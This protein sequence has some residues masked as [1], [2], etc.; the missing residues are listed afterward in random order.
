MENDDYRAI[1]IDELES[2]RQRNPRYS[3]RAFARDLGL[4]ADQLSAILKRR[5][6]LSGARAER[7]AGKLGLGEAETL[8]FRTMV[9]ASHARSPTQRAAARRTLA[10]STKSVGVLELDAFKVVAEWHHFAILE[11]ADLDGGLLDEKTIAPRLKIGKRAA[12]AAVLRLVRLGLLARDTCA[13][14]AT[15]GQTFAPIGVSDRSKRRFLGQ[16]G[17]KALQALEEQASEDRDFASDMLSIGAGDIEE[18][19]A[20]VRTFRRGLAALADKPGKKDRVLCVN[21]QA[22]EIAR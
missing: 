21:V 12:S 11:L 1:L 4:P 19:R 15:S 2:R 17:Q 18:L 14:R 22:F 10:A 20:L 16:L 9:E 8:V 3:L 5:Y 13:L 7:V 6:G